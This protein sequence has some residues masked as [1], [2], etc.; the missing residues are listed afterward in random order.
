M[1]PGDAGRV[2][3]Q[4]WWPRGMEP[5]DPEPPE[6]TFTRTVVAARTDLR[7]ARDAGQLL[8][9]CHRYATWLTAVGEPLDPAT[10]FATALVTRYRDN[11]LH[12]KPPGTQHATCS[13]LRRLG[14]AAD[15]AEPGAEAG[16]IERALDTFVPDRLAP[17]RFAAVE[18]LVRD[19]ARRC[20]PDSVSRARSYLRYGAYLAAWAD[21]SSRPLRL[22]V[23]F[24]PDTVEAFARLL[25]TSAPASAAT[26]A[27]VLRSMAR[28][29]FPEVTP[30]TR[31][32][33]GRPP[34]QNPPYTDDEIDTLFDCADRLPRLKRRRHVTALLLLGIAAGA[35]AGE[36]NWVRPDDV[37]VISQAV[38]RVAL[39]RSADSEAR[40]VEV[41]GDYAQR[42]ADLALRARTAGETWLIGG[43][44]R[45]NRASVLCADTAR[46]W[47]VRINSFRMRNTYL[48][49]LA[50]THDLSGLLSAA[51]MTSLEPFDEILGHLRE[52]RSADSS[53]ID[54]SITDD[55]LHPDDTD[56]EQA[57]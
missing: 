44:A 3:A 52:S 17:G 7:D 22:D 47:P 21:A 9:A 13:R 14:T 31:L 39:R 30:A 27:S 23:V 41:R 8:A 48:A 4:A 26:V 57:S 19:A 15:A 40:M 18:G 42:L 50:L 33:H 5:T 45:R 29:L 55:A 46:S 20:H 38:V 51:G 2:R 25:V 43:D 10:A 34:V 32:T 16:A 49:N 6:I 11:E 12:D 28:T 35:H 53:P 24:H 36:P 1:T 56:F 54:L 37:E